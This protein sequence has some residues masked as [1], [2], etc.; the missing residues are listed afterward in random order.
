[1]RPDGQDG[2]PRRLT[3]L[4][5]K[6]AEDANSNQYAYQSACFEKIREGQIQEAIEMA[7]K[8]FENKD[9]ASYHDLVLLQGQ[10]H[11]L[12]QSVHL[13]TLHQSESQIQ[14]NKIMVALIDLVK[15]IKG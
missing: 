5:Q 6:K 3:Q 11:L 7:S 12:Q 10:Y 9:E 4:M 13:N 15:D 1:M 8:W 2:V 14:R